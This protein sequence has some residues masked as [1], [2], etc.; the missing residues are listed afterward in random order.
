MNSG[1]RS[2]GNVKSVGIRFNV[3][4]PSDVAVTSEIRSAQDDDGYRLDFYT[5]YSSDSQNTMT[6]RDGK[7]G[8]GTTSPGSH[9]L[10]VEGTSYTSGQINSGASL[11]APTYYLGEYI[12][13][14]GDTNTRFGFPDTYT[15]AFY[16]NNAEV[17]R[18]DSNQRVGIG[19]SSPDYT[20]DIASG[21]TARLPDTIYLRN[22]SN[23]WI[24]TY[25]GTTPSTAGWIT[26]G[27]WR[28][29]V[30]V[31]F[32]VCGEKSGQHNEICFTCTSLYTHDAG[33]IIH[34]SADHS[35]H[36]VTK[37][38]MVSD[39]DNTIY[40]RIRVE[41]YHTGGVGLTVRTESMSRGDQ[42][43]DG[44]VGTAAASVPSAGSVLKEVDVFY[45]NGIGVFGGNIRAS[46]DIHLGYHIKHENDT[47]TYFGFPTGT[48]NT[49][50]LATNSNERMRIDSAGN[51]GIG[52][53]SPPQK[54]TV[55]TGTTSDGILLYNE[56]NKKLI[57]IERSGIATYGYISLYDGATNTTRIHIHNNH[58]S[59]INVPSYNFGIGINVPDEKLHVEGSIKVDNPGTIWLASYIKHLP[60]SEN[61][62]NGF[63]QANTIIFGTNN[64]ERMRIDSAGEVGIGTTSPAALLDIQAPAGDTKLL[65][66][67][68]ERPWL[69]QS[70]RAT[71]SSASTSN[72]R[73]TSSTSAKWFYI[74]L[75]TNLDGVHIAQVKEYQYLVFIRTR[76]TI[77]YMLEINWASARASPETN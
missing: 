46:G 58:H 51:V 56:N 63:P 4:E 19:T 70:I 17:M 1:T 12:R 35:G 5:T 18:I 16:S 65:R 32:I 11:N 41:I 27:A 15:I 29:R 31:K 64:A 20:L 34:S 73:L 21:K 8:I 60:T 2:S 25:S 69:F 14:V 45:G 52:H 40:S 59:Y 22:F 37:I 48:T 71:S 75:D 33:I 28:S 47:G 6:L 50:I 76:V 66:L 57:G 9:K 74:D 43:A 7:V 26:L 55:K 54:L 62:Y 68:S 53:T 13:H 24:K 49:I 30:N 3:Y 23:E 42:V 38:R 44:A 67:G 61:T 72:L 77:R 36:S 10:Y 39:G